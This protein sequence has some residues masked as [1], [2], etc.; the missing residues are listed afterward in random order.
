MGRRRDHRCKVSN[1]L[2]YNLN[3][4]HRMLTHRLWFRFE[5]VM[6][7]TLRYSF[8][9]SLLLT[10]AGLYFHQ[11]GSGTNVISRQLCELQKSDRRWRL[12]GLKEVHGRRYMLRT[13]A[14]ELFFAD[15][16]ELFLNFSRG[17]KER[18]RFYAKLR[19]SCKVSLRFRVKWE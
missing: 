8:E 2:C 12:N 3:C 7:V 13:Q 15:G 9:G 1:S 5:E 10:T 16:R 14:L 4:K 19:N 11:V 18:N 17:I 6:V